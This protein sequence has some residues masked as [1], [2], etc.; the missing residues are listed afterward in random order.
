MDSNRID[1]NNLEDFTVN[2]K[3]KLSTLWAATTL[4]YFYGDYFELYLPGKVEELLNGENLLGS[5]EKLLAASVLLVITAITVFLSV[6]LKPKINGLLNN[7]FGILFT[8]IMLL[9]AFTPLVPWKAF[10]V[11]LALVESTLT[12]LITYNV[13]KLP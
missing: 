13:W 8:A 7:I 11:F 10:Y 6:V 12:I 4:C 9:T 5:P 2:I 3:I 1:K